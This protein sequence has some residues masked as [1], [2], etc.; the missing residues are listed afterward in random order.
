MDMTDMPDRDDS[1]RIFVGNLPMDIREREIDDIFYKF[2]RISD[3]EIKRPQR[4]PAFSFVTFSDP[5]DANDAV[6]YRDGY[7]LFGDVFIRVEWQGGRGG[8]GGG[9]GRYGREPPRSRGFGGDRYGGDRYGDERRETPRGWGYDDG[10]RGGDPA[11]WRG[12]GDDRGD[13]DTQLKKKR[14]RD[15]ES[16]K[17]RDDSDGSHDD[18]VGHYKGGPGDIIDGKCER[19]RCLA[20]LCVR[21]VSLVPVA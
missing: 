20:C 4:P 17:K 12:Y 10:H 9:G 15:G 21:R 3:I 5:R 11:R 16:Q 7:R 8:G 14:P 13:G 1:R 2:G 19:S 18:T 6:H